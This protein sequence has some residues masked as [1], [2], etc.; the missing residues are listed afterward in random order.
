[1]KLVIVGGVAGGASAATRAR[2][3]SETAEIVMFERGPDVSFANCGLPY[4]IGGIIADREKLL[5]AK[6]QLLRDRFGIDVRTLSEVRSIDRERKVVRVEDLDSGR[7]YEESYDRLILATGAAPIRPP[8]PGLDLPGVHTLRNL[9]DTDRIKEIVDRGARRA[10]VVGAGFIGI[11]VVENLVHRGVAVTLVELSDQILPPFDREMTTPFEQLLRAKGVDV[12]LG[13]AAEAF[14]QESDHLKVKLRS[15]IVVETDLVLVGIGVRPENILATAAGLETGPRGGIRVD[16]AMRTSDPA[17][18]AVGDAVETVDFPFGAP[19]QIPLAGPAN[20]QGRLA[21]DHIFGREVA[22]R[23]TQGTAIVGAFGAALAATGMNAKSLDRAGRPYQAIYVH[24][25]DHAGYYPGA[26]RL[27]IKLLFDPAD[28]KVLGAQVVG[29]AGVDNRINVLAIA[30]QAG[31]TVFDLEQVELAYAPQFGSAKDAVNMAGFVAAGVVRG[32]SR[33]VLP[34]QLE[35][36][37]AMLIDVRSPAEF[38]RGTIPG[39]T[40]IPVDVLRNR[41]G[42]LPRDRRLV[43]FCQVGQRGYVATRILMQHGFDVRNLS[44]GFTTYQMARPT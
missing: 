3:L 24:P 44:G 18:S 30:I 19:T 4:Y 41:L 1:M 22:Y 13:D 42:D 10:V 35:A 14:E 31:M 8:I 26:S 16:R 38:A 21:V 23:G 25:N 7:T 43:V 29:S 34:D 37:D 28:G 27:S 6:P 11:E 5:V 39:A 33:V 40:N 15:G 2:R 20:R 12:R 9:A 32:D 17:I 36:I